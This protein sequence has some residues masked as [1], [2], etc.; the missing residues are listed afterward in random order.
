MTPSIVSKKACNTPSET[1]CTR[2]KK[3]KIPL[4]IAVYILYCIQRKL[5]VNIA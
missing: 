5:A 2:E 3:F 4:Y 1:S